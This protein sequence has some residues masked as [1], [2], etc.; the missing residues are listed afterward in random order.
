MK[1]LLTLLILTVSAGSMLSA[2]YSNRNCDANRNCGGCRSGCGG[3]AV[4]QNRNYQYSQQQRQP[5]GY[6]QQNQGYYNHGDAQKQKE[7]NYNQNG[8]TTFQNDRDLTN[9]VQDSFRS[10][11]SDK[12]DN[13]SVS[14]NNGNVVLTGSVASQDDKNSL[15]EKVR[16]V[17]G[18]K[19]IN[20]QI[21]VQG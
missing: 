17:P 15:E 2:D 13:V 7:N 20:N 6:A 18:V 9:K 3:N 16:S 12:Y 4:N 8:R 11:F 21:R 1:T 10:A 19:S 14:V 5:G